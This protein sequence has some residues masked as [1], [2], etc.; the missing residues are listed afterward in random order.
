MSSKS[1]R[2]IK[3]FS[4]SEDN[5]VYIR[6]QGVSNLIEAKVLELKLDDQGNYKSILLDRI[7]HRSHEDYFECFFDSGWKKGFYVTGAFVS[8]LTR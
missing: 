6:F 3:Q 1:N 4:I 7:I 8:E 2:V 5:R